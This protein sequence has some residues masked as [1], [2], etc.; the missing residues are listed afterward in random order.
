MTKPT[1]YALG[2]TCSLKLPL[3]LRRQRQIEKRRDGVMRNSNRRAPSQ[4]S[5]A[6]SRKEF[7][8]FAFDKIR[9]AT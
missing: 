9:E 2:G 3:C 7:R 1:E 6:V 4:R 8:P 5:G